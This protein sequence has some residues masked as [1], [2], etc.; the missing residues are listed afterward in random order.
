MLACF[1]KNELEAQNCPDFYFGVCL[2][3]PPLTSPQAAAVMVLSGSAQL[4]T[5]LSFPRLVWGVP[6]QGGGTGDVDGGFWR[7]GSYRST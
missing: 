4:L 2:F 1:T 5:E 3:F 7:G 6:L